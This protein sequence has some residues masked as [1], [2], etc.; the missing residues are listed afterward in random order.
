MINCKIIDL[1]AKI[2]IW[3][4]RNRLYLQANLALK[5][6]VCPIES[7]SWIGFFNGNRALILRRIIHQR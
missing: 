4:H 1:S 3:F 2:K 7:C 6:R 5:N